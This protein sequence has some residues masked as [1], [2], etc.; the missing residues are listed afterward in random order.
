M[1]PQYNNNMMIK[2]YRVE[3]KKKKV[4]ECQEIF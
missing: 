3:E 2:K 1:Y 4:N